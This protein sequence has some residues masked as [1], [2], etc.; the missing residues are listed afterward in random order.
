MDV[1][2]NRHSLKLNYVPEKKKKVPNN[3][4]EVLSEL[5]I[6]E[7]EWHHDVNEKNMLSSTK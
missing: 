6:A 4:K 2:K 5:F 1:N 3:T 7:Y